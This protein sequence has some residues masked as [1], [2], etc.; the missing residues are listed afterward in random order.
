MA[1]PHGFAQPGD[2]SSIKHPRGIFRN[3][4]MIADLRE[5]QS[6]PDSQVNDSTMP[7]R[8]LSERRIEGLVRGVPLS[9]LAR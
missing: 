1:W 9:G 3:A 6:I 4:Q 5:C 2:G 8:E 7:F